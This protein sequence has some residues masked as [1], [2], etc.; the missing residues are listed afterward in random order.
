MKKVLVWVMGIAIG[1][2]ILYMVGP[3]EK[4]R[5]L[6]GEYPEVPSDLTELENLIRQKED[7][8][9]GLKH[10][11]EARI[12]WADPENKSKTPYSIVYIHGFGASQME[13][14]P[15]HRKIAEKFGANL[16]LSRLPEH[17]IKRDDAFSLLSPEKL[18]QGAREAFAIAQN[19]GDSVIVIGT[20]MGGALSLVVAS[21]RP[22]I[23]GLLLYSPCI[24]VY[25]DPL[26]AFFTPW[27]TVLMKS[28]M[29]NKDGVQLV[30]REGDKAKYWAEEYHINAYTSLA[31]LL[32]SK[33]NRQTFSQINQPIFLG[34]YYQDEENQDKV[35]S[36]PAM[37]KM[38][39]AINTKEH[40]K[41]KT[42]FPTAG[43]HVISSSI[44]NEDWDEVYKAS[45]S[46]IEDIL[47]VRPVP[48]LEENP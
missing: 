6:E 36:V 28:F 10:N 23:K 5:A 9:R 41:V 11:N 45:C 29:T 4:I 24:E 21:E 37:L 7:T 12:I 39:D 38:Y 30:E 3:K 32:K 26:S 34:Y 18:V 19:L 8:V 33:M 14:D 40:L 27:A 2:A 44:T 15:V 13:G 17:G 48:E 1:L 16:Y 31:I 35:V 46:F 42:P 43:D 47:K 20:S 22:D 25:G